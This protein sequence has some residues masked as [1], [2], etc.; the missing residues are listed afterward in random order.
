MFKITSYR[1]EYPIY[2]SISFNF[3]ILDKENTRFETS[4]NDKSN[5]SINE[6]SDELNN[7]LTLEVDENPDSCDENMVSL[8]MKCSLSYQK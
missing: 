7:D 6:K 1:N 5:K 3:Q 2:V 8:L 4:L